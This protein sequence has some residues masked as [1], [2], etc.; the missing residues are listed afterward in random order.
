MVMPLIQRD[1]KLPSRLFRNEATDLE[2]RGEGDD[3]YPDLGA[4]KGGEGFVYRA[5]VRRGE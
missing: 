4:H 1:A 2:F 5:W 3:A